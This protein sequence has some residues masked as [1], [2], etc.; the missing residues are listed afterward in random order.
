MLLMIKIIKVEY[1][2]FF[3]LLLI[4]ANLASVL[5]AGVFSLLGPLYGI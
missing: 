1:I 4:P 5:S 3:L 2:K